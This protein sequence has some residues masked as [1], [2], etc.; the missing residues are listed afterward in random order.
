MREWRASPRPR[1]R[2]SLAV[3]LLI[4]PIASARALAG[5]GRIAEVEGAAFATD[6]GAVLVLNDASFTGTLEASARL[7]QALGEVE[8][9]LLRRGPSEDPSDSDVQAVRFARGQMD[10]K[11]APGLVMSGLDDLCEKLILEVVDLAELQSVTSVIDTASM[12]KF[13]A[14]RALKS[15]RKKKS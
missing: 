6:H 12:S 10:Q 7:S 4:T 15:G 13:A 2:C 14:I 3:A 1:V 11:L 8:L 5:L 9:L